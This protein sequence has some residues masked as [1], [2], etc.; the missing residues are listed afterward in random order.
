M[1]GN[2]FL[3]SNQWKKNPQSASKN[4]DYQLLICNG[5]S[6]YGSKG[7]L[8]AYLELYHIINLWRASILEFSYDHW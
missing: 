2:P 3:L 1:I 7:I 5:D 8:V 6:S 4:P